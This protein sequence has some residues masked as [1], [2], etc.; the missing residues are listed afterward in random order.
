M[1]STWKIINNERGITHQDM[2]ASLLKLDNKL[3][4]NQHKI[5]NLFNSYFL[6]VSESI[7]GNRNKEVNSTMNNPINCIFKH[8]KKPFTKIDWK[9]VSTYGIRNIIKS[10]KPKIH[11]DMMKFRTE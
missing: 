10:L 2:S 8:Y 6:S 11:M 7:K 4:A 9:Y 1:K 5:A 3:I